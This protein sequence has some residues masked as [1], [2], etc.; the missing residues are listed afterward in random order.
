[1]LQG[2]NL[3]PSASVIEGKSRGTQHLSPYSILFAERRNSEW[4]G[5]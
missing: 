1:M 3:L 5:I 4:I 2:R